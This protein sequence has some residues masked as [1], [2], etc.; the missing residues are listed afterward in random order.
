MDKDRII[1]LYISGGPGF[2]QFY[3]G[4]TDKGIFLLVTWVISMGLF[5]LVF[6]NSNAV[7][8]AILLLAIAIGIQTYGFIDAVFI[9]YKKNEYKLSGYEQEKFD[10]Q[11]K[12]AGFGPKKDGTAPIV[13]EGGFQRKVKG[14]PDFKPLDP[15]PEEDSKS[16]NKNH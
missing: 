5:F 10:Q 9:G 12:E 3:N 7:W 15:L 13:P 8:V 11:M 2:G 6:L 4:E 1:L 14:S 16:K